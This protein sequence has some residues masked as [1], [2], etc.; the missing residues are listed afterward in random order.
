MRTAL[1]FLALLYFF[2]GVAIVTDIFMASVEV[3]TSK[4]KKLY[5]SKGAEKIHKG[6]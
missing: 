5:L 4:T 2:L 1:Y 6:K 3:I